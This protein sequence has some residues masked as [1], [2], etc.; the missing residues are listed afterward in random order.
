[1]ISLDGGLS[2]EEQRGGEPG[3]LKIYLRPPDEVSRNPVHDNPLIMALNVANWIDQLHQVQQ[4][5]ADSMIRLIAVLIKKT[6]KNRQ[7]VGA[8]T[9]NKELQC[10]CFGCLTLVSSFALHQDCD[11]ATCLVVLE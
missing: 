1:M 7:N 8:T 10:T 2:M 4:D 6:R 11:C 9:L 3:R 5:P